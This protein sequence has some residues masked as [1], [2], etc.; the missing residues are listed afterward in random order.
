MS[1]IVYLDYGC[2]DGMFTVAMAKHFN[3]LPH[4]VWAVDLIDK[5]KLIEEAGYNYIKATQQNI[6]EMLLK[7][8]EVNL[9]TIV[10]VIH[11]I[12]PNIKPPVCSPSQEP[13]H[14]DS[15]LPMLI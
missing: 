9:V 10:N 12:P 6:E 5:P 7:L 4:N 3:I 15:C 11:H 2:N 1:N 8:P 14:I 13:Q